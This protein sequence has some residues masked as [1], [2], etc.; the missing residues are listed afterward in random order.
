V[1]MVAALE[2]YTAI[3]GEWILDTPQL[4]AIGVNPVMLDLIRWH[5]AEEVEHKAVA[6]DTMKHLRAGYWRQVR[7]QLLVTP[8]L[9]WLFV[10]GVRFMYSVD[11]HLPPGAKP[12]WRDYFAAARRGLV[13]GPFEFLG[14]IGAYYKPSF[15]PSQLGGVGR[16]VDYLARSPAA[17]AS[18]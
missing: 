11:P 4:D 3:L 14:V 10:R 12:R 2:H 1:S 5:G 7:T 16:A 6:F 15:H 9:L 17:R 13:P 18:H 8:A